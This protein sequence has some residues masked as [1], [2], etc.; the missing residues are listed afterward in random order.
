MI[1]FIYL[2]DGQSIYSS[3]FKYYYLYEDIYNH[4]CPTPILP[5]AFTTSS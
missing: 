5:K 3:A 4:Q 1:I 2:I